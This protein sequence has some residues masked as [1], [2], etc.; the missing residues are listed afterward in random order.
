M[1]KYTKYVWQYWSLSIL[2]YKHNYKFFFLIF[3]YYCFNL[4]FLIFFRYWNMG[5]HK[6]YLKVGQNARDQI[7]GLGRGGRTSSPLSMLISKGAKLN[8]S[9]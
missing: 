2:D 4:K 8:N 5:L 6:Q 3:N 9:E 7:F 1:L